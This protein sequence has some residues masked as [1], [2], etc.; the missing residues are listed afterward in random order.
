VTA[1]GR[2]AV[3]P[4]GGAASGDRVAELRRQ[5]LVVIPACL[6]LCLAGAGVHARSSLRSELAWAQPLAGADSHPVEAVN[7]LSSE[8]LRGFTPEV[9]R[10]SAEIQRWAAEYGLPV[11][12][13]A[14]VMQIES[15][16][17]PQVVSSAGAQGLFQV[18][19]Y[20][21]VE[22]ENPQDPETNARR[23]LAYL[24]GALADGGGQLDLALA[25]YN[26]GRGLIVQPRETWPE[27]T[28]RYVAWGMGIL[29]DLESTSAESAN[30]QAWLAAGGARLCDRAAHVLGPSG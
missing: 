28:R 6:G 9:R 16:G 26:G 12:L 18:M 8:A 17:H 7:G 13:V 3:R 20:H 5:L 15:C 23:G 4:A 29:S 30:L 22:G 14:T 21:F 2:R 19:P 27:E 1:L 25:G 24:A 11:T 10:W